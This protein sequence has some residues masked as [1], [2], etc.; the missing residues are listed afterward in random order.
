[1]SIKKT[2]LNFKTNLFR[3]SFIVIFLLLCL[4][5]ALNLLYYHYQLIVD[6]NP[7]AYR[8]GG[9]LL[10]TDYLIKGINPFNIES[11]P[12]AY[13]AYGIVYH[14]VVYPFAKLFGSTLLIHRL[15]TGIFI[16]LSCY[17]LL[18]ALL[19]SN[20]KF[21][22]LIPALLIF[23]ISLLFN[24]S[25]LSKPCSVGEFLFLCSV[26]IPFIHNYRNKSLFI[27]IITGL[28]AFY[29]KP[30]FILGSVIL[31]LYLFLFKSKKIGFLYS[32]IFGVMFLVSAF[33]VNLF[34]DS[35]FLNTMYVNVVVAS[36][37]L[38]HVIQQF[39]DF[40]ILNIGLI[41]ILILIVS[42]ILVRNVEFIK[43][44]IISFRWI[45]G[46]SSKMNLFN[47]TSP[48]VRTNISL[49]L[50]GVIVTSLIV[51]LKLSGHNGNWMVYLFQLI[52]PFFILLTFSLIANKPDKIF[53]IIIPL[54]TLSLFLYYSYLPHKHYTCNEWNKINQLI[55]SNE[56]ILNSPAIAPLLIENNKRLYDSGQTEYYL[57]MANR[58]ENQF[59]NS[60]AKY[61]FINSRL[62]KYK[63]KIIKSAKDYNRDINEQLKNKK[64]D[65]VI[66]TDMR[67]PVV[68]MDTVNK[69]YQKYDSVTVCM[70]H[71]SSWKLNIYQK[72]N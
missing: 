50:F 56:N 12:L 49:A 57:Y 32:V 53:V 72:R 8:E 48:L 35:Y 15:V 10:I 18:L 66:L 45:D 5:F 14:I 63:S 19:K 9:I 62:S 3:N 58:V 31:G 37:Y 46:I 61:D 25:S 40:T 13:N 38:P 71:T 6:P 23:Y 17:I 11:M 65:V 39:S 59:F 16:L 30:Y 33:F 51:A 4:Y 55:E 70:S 60:L 24:D 28:L 69:Y 29:T 41:A 67:S 26:L 54:L 44:N 52:S 36:N 21:Y 68:S 22:L 1:M 27:S 42:E 64:F 47:M 20:V 43:F 2:I 7:Q 34:F